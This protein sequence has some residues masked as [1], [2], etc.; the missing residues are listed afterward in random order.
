MKLKLPAK[1]LDYLL[2]GIVS[3]II[4]GLILVIV[5]GATSSAL[6]MFAENVKTA[7]SLPKA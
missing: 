3:G 4:A 2:L 7:A 5:F 6:A 1:T